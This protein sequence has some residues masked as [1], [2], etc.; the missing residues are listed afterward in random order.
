MSEFLIKK[1]YP[2]IGGKLVEKSL[3]PPKKTPYVCEV[4]D[5]AYINLHGIKKI[6]KQMKKQPEKE[7]ICENK[8]QKL[9]FKKKRG[10]PSKKDQ[11]IKQA[12]V[13]FGDFIDH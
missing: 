10:R 2:Q 9:L 8:K 3:V 12:K 4:I 13:D 1:E 6:T 11:M 7:W 5:D